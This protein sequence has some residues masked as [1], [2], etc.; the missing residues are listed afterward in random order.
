MCDLAAP[1]SEPGSLSDGD[2]V[3]KTYAIVAAGSRLSTLLL[4]YCGEGP[5]A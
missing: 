1:V 4:T 2:G 3:D 5:F